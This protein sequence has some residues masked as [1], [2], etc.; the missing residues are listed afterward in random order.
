MLKPE[1]L[2]KVNNYILQPR[3]TLDLNRYS[4]HSLL[5]PQILWQSVNY[6]SVVLY[7]A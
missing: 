3:V 2:T 4:H 7:P 6:H 5:S 1:F